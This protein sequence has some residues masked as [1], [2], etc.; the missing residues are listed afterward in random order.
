MNS[1][2]SRYSFEM[3]PLR[4]H[5]STFPSLLFMLWRFQ[6]DLLDLGGI[7]L[8]YLARR[9]GPSG[10][11]EIIQVPLNLDP[12]NYLYYKENTLESSIALPEPH[13]AVLLLS[14]RCNFTCRYCF[15]GGGYRVNDINTND[16]IKIVNELGSLKIIRCMVSGGE[17]TLH[18]GI[19]PILDALLKNEIFPYLATNGSKLT[20]KMVASF[21]HIGLKFVQVSLDTIDRDIYSYLTG[22]DCLR[23]VLNGIELLI[24]AGIAVGIKAVVTKV[25]AQDV[26]NLVSFASSAGISKVIFE[27]YSPSAMG[28]IDRELFLNQEQYK[29]VIKAIREQQEKHK[30]DI[31]IKVPEKIPRWKNFESIIYCGAFLTSLTINSQGEA[32]C[33][34]QFDDKKLRPG[35]LLRNSVMSVWN[36]E[37]MKDIRELRNMEVD[38]ICSSC[39]YFEKCRTG[40][41]SISQLY[42]GNP[43]SPD[44]RCWKASIRGLDEVYE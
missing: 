22:V 24:G 11:K 42:T 33:C 21:E 12:L 27:L 31:K 4:G 1:G 34:D 13:Q 9:S 28:G 25:N 36:S 40:C 5:H 23:S 39:E 26:V 32:I 30:D 17:P 41:P 2:E 15:R 8:P 10:E 16:W 6:L 20:P 14:E 3:H 29:M 35:S 37:K 18:G 38:P 44:P 43:F 7:F 19:V